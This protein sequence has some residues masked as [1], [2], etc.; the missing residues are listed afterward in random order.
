MTGVPVPARSSSRRRSSGTS[1][2]GGRSTRAA[3]SCDHLGHGDG[4]TRRVARDVGKRDGPS[5]RP[6]TVRRRRRRQPLGH[7]RRPQAAVGEC[8]PHD[9]GRQPTLTSLP[10]AERDADE[11]AS[12]GSDVVTGSVNGSRKARFPHAA[13]HQSMLMAIG[14]HPTLPRSRGNRAAVAIHRSIV[15]PDQPVQ[16][17]DDGS[18][19]ISTVGSSTF[20]RGFLTARL[21]H[22]A[23]E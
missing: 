11:R 22:D 1:L 21:E 14:T 23:A 8:H 5:D 12:V 6:I 15:G 3:R 19:S 13:D 10:C 17:N 16:K 4:V 9:V 2:A 7:A 18:R 20:G